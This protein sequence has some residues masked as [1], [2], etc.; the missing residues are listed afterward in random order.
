MGE[1]AK[2]SQVKGID[3][4]TG[5]TYIYKAD[6][7]GNVFARYNFAT[8]KWE[9][10]PFPC[11]NQFTR[12]ISP[13]ESKEIIRHW[14]E[15]G[16]IKPTTSYILIGDEPKGVAVIDLKTHLPTHDYD[17]MRELLKLMP[18]SYL[19]PWFMK[20]IWGSLAGPVTPVLPSENYIGQMYDEIKGGKKKDEDLVWGAMVDLFNVANLEYVNLNKLMPWDW[21]EEK[22]RAYLIKESKTGLDEL[23]EKFD[24]F[25]KDVL[26]EDPVAQSLIE[27]YNKLPKNPDPGLEI[28][29][30]FA[31]S[32]LLKKK[33]YNA[34]KGVIDAYRFANETILGDALSAPVP[35]DVVASGRTIRATPL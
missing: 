30:Q 32:E 2:E 23:R 3:P 18:R 19:R 22:L 15:Q 1:F 17:T 21:E 26:G 35:F 5:M 12:A 9:G 8:R 7:N 6:E 28:S 10:K 34:V 31:I 24:A 13:E 20:E 27:E 33:E 25:R 11:P 14:A 16:F 4:T 29:R